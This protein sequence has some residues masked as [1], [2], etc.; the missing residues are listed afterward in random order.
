MM[1]QP[2]VQKIFVKPREAAV[3]LDC[4]VSKTYELIASGAIP[5]VR[6]E[7]DRMI[8]IPLAA[9]MKLAADAEATV[10]QDAR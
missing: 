5:S 4:S 8:R 3:L 7:G 1:L 2:K 10:E 6:L 9:L